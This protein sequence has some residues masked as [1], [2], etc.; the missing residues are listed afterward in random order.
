LALAYAR[1]INEELR[2]LA[3]AGI[4]VLQLDEPYLQANPDAAR[5]FA[6]EAI[7]LA[8]DG[9]AATT[10]LHTC[11]GYAAYVSNKTSGYP[12][13]AELVDAPVSWV[14]IETAQPKLDPAIVGYLSPRSV[15]MGVLDLG[16]HDVERPDAIAERIRTALRHIDPTCLALSPDCGMKYLPRAVAKAKLAA[17]VEAAHIVRS[18]LLR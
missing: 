12:F 4:D 7:S 5:Q 16:T 10:T 6:I 1:A 8:V 2:D 11:Y 3:A 13:F 17:M 18:E 15:I 14:A 9:I